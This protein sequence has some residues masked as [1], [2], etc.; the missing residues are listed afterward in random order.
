MPMEPGR[1][2]PVMLESW[3]EPD[4]RLAS[5]AKAVGEPAPICN[6]MYWNPPV[7]CQFCGNGKKEFP[8]F[9]AGDSNEGFSRE[10][11]VATRLSNQI[12][13]RPEVGAVVLV[14]LTPSAWPAVAETPV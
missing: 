2:E 6:P 4:S 5:A 10:K 8:G 11:L 3:K 9:M 1:S 7:P 12:S 13:E 14:M